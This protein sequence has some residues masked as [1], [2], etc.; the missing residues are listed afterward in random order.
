MIPFVILA[1]EN[2]DDREFM[3]NLYLSYNRLMYSEIQ[4]IAKDSWTTDDILQSVIVKLID[5]DKI[6]LLRTLSRAKLV[7]YLI[8]ASK[9][10]A[11]NFLRDKKR[12]TEF[13]FDDDID[14]VTYMDSGPEERLLLDDLTDRV[15]GIW[16]SL[17]DRSRHVLELKYVLEK[18]NAEIAEEL[19]MQPDSARMAITRARKSLKKKLSETEAI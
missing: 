16:K 4:K 2:P 18:T 17:D 5:K 19:G 8:S 13:S 9:N 6:P 15:N 1:I 12:A 3:E 10:T 7:N 11:Y 14:S